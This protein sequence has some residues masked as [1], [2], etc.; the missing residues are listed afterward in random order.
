MSEYKWRNFYSTVEI[1]KG[2]SPKV[3]SLWNKKVQEAEE[4]MAH[5]VRYAVFEDSYRRYRR[6]KNRCQRCGLK[7]RPLL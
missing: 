7:K 6:G 4:C 3:V 5:G 1:G 2:V